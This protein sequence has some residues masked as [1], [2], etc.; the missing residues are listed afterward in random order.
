[1]P[2]SA[3]AASH[4]VIRQI[5]E[6][7]DDFGAS[8]TGQGRKIQVEFVSANPTGPLHVGHG[9]GAAYGATLANLLAICGLRVLVLEREADIYGG[10]SQMG[11]VIRA[12][13]LVPDAVRQRERFLRA[14]T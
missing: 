4:A 13:S 12:M 9:R 6:Q 2:A 10:R 14:F 7:G 11:N 8:N 1:M 3:S 5:R